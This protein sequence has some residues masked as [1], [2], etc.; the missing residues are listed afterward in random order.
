MEENLTRINV[1]VISEE[2]MATNM[3][4]KVLTP[5]DLEYTFA[6]IVPDLE[7]PWDLMN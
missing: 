4:P 2:E 7:Q 3:I 1:W 5:D 6:V